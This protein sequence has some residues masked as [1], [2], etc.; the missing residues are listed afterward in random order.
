[1]TG[2]AAAAHPGVSGG[3]GG[4]GPARRGGPDQDTRLRLSQPPTLGLFAPM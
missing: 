2:G 3:G 1:V 4:R